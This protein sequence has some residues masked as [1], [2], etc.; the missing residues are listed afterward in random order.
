MSVI[1]AGPI[2]EGISRWSGR[3]A[4]EDVLH[5]RFWCVS[6]KTCVMIPGCRGIARSAS[7]SPCE[8]RERREDSMC[9]SAGRYVPRGKTVR[10]SV[11]GSSGGGRWTVPRGHSGHP[12]TG[13]D[14]VPRLSRTRGAGRA[15]RPELAAPAALQVGEDVLAAGAHRRG[16]VS[17]SLVC[18]RQ[19]GDAQRPKNDR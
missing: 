5:A 19:P 16:A 10:Q 7:R 11:S 18:V 12:A 3:L 14:L 17:G 1:E 6:D 8:S 9:S 15:V 2:R 13:E 4:M